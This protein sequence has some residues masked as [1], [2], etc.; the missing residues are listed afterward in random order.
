MHAASA[1][2]QSVGHF[3][4][5]K[6]SS[7]NGCLLHFAGTQPLFQSS[8]LLRA[9]YSQTLDITA[10]AFACLQSFHL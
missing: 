7:S 10:P 3:Q 2:S 6:C 4:N 8:A 5:D 1:V 9:I